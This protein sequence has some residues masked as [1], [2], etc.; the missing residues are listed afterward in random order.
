MKETIRTDRAPEPVGP[1]AQAISSGG[2]VFVSGQVAPGGGDVRLETRR[3]L[4]Q[5]GAILE[6]AGSS[7]EKVVRCGVFL[8]EMGDFSAMNEVYAEFFGVSRPARSTVQAVAL[9]LGAA[10]EIDCIALR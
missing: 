2:F 4:E 8:R 1:Y 6:A 7:L 9:P 5:I 10:V 3:V